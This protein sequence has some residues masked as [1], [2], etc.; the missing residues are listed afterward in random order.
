MFL[1]QLTPLEKET[2]ISLSI[3]AAKANGV[4][5]DEEYAMI[6]EYCK[7]M[8]IAF[9]DVHNLKSMD[10]VIDVFGQ[11]SAQTKKIVLLELLGLLYAD[12]AYDDTE[13]SFAC[14]YVSKVGLSEKTLEDM[15]VLI[16]KYLAIVKEISTTI[17]Q[18]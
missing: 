13:K 2:F 18:I 12:G 10:A 16:E 11:A 9:F 1:N 3:H 7:E 8:G 4:F 15:T 6:E 5:A 17:Y 14:E